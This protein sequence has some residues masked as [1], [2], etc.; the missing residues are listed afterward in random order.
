MKNSKVVLIT[1]SSSG[2][3]LLTAN[4]L[5]K[6]GYIVYASMRK[7]STKNKYI[8]SIL[9][10]KQNINIIELDVRDDESITNAI[11]AIIKKEKRIDILINNAAIGAMGVTEQFSI[12]DFIK[13]YDTNV[14]GVFRVTKK[15]LP[16]MRKNNSGLIIFISSI[17]GRFAA[18]FY[19]IYSSTKFALEALAEA[20]SF[21]CR[22]VGI[23]MIIVEPG[24]FPTTSFGNNMQNHK[25]TGNISLDEYGSLANVPTEISLHFQEMERTQQFQSPDSF[26]EQIIDI[27]SNPKT[28]NLRV[29]IDN[30]CGL[31]VDEFNS[32]SD[33]INKVLIKNLGM[34]TLLLNNK[35]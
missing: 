21:E 29:V 25:P 3:G 14:F 23:D 16:H 2:F 6:E 33:K 13:Q 27:I 10:A 5:A 30:D 7:I 19:S 26:V 18:P 28:K 1:G 11:Q 15:V 8:A 20:W 9:R 4:A 17:M 24:A 34:K 32:K 35:D 12:N 31:I 22:Q